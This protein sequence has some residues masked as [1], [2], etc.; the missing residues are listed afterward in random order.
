M[1]ESACAQCGVLWQEEEL[2]KREDNGQIVCPEC[3]GLMKDENL[4]CQYDESG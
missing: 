2:L 4:S 3:S 1:K